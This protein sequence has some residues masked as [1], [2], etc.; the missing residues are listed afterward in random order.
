M[1]LA[2]G[3]SVLLAVLID[4]AAHRASLCTVRAGLDCLFMRCQ[5]RMVFDGAALP[6]V[7]SRLVA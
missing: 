4:Y 3:L 5:S 7:F 2:N 1:T 6:P